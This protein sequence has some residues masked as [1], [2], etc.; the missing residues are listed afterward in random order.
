MADNKNKRD[1]NNNQSNTDVQVVQVSVRNLVE[2]ILRQGDIDNRTTGSMDK[3]A[4]LKG[5][6]I[7][8][9]IQS[10]MGS[11]YR[12]E[13][14]LK[15]RVSFNDMDILVEGRADGIFADG[16]EDTITI[17]EIKGVLRDLF[18]ITK[19]DEIDLAQGKCYAYMYALE[20]GLKE[21]KVQMTYCQMDTEE[22]ERFVEHFQVADLERWFLDLVS[23]YEK[24]A[25][26][27]YEWRLKRNESIRNTDFPFEYR[28]GQKE[29]ITSVYTTIMRKK[30][31]FIQAPTG[32]GKT[33]ATVFPSVKAVGEELGEK[34]FYLTAKTITRT[35]AE[36]AFKLLQD[37]GLIWKSITLTAKEKICFYEE[38][39]CNPEYCEYAKGHYDRINDTLYEM[40]INEDEV[41]RETIE[42]YAGK[43]QVCPYEMSLD[44]SLWADSV[45]CDYNYAFDPNVHLKR[46]FAAGNSGSYLFLVD[47]AH[48]LVER[49]REMYSATLYKEEILSVRRLVKKKAPKLAKRLEESNKQFLTLKKEC[50]SWQVQDSISHVYL[51]LLSIMTEMEGLFENNS[52]HDLANGKSKSQNI[53]PFQ[54]IDL[55][56]GEDGL[57]NEKVK[58]LEES[59]RK[60]ILDLYFQIRHFLNMYELLDDNYVVYTEHESDGR[61]KLKLYCVNPAKNLQEFLRRGNSTIFFSATLLPIHYY[62]KLLSVEADDYA[63]YA[64]STFLKQNRKLLIGTDVSTKYTKRTPKMYSEIAH[65]ILE[66]VK[67]RAG[68]YIAFFPSYKFMEEVFHV[69][70]ETAK[71]CTLSNSEIEWVIQSK[72]MNEEAREIFLENFEEDRDNSLVGFCVLGGIFS[73][74][75]DLANEKLIGAIIVGTGLPQIG[76]EREILK[77]HFDSMAMPGFDYAYLYPGMNKVLQ[78]AGRVIRTET[79][80][81]VILLLDERFLQRQYQEMFPREWSEIQTCKREDVLGYLEKFW[82]TEEM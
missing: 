77:Q 55:T 18:Y 47:E 81:G 16:S 9:K 67:G 31:L 36:H 49:G 69:F 82:N 19:P 35:V 57:G 39:N 40:L 34:V 53:E 59:D 27:A 1:K 46:F 63:V 5:S 71:A 2:F 80:K 72:Y 10:R 70:V 74:G 24:W 25:R 60:K 33:L 22:I 14:P 75:I 11:N 6:R 50:E 3:N 29:L 62:K 15:T 73:E 78:A 17:D 66:T 58:H 51:K 28:E 20:Q 41:K 42:E 37:K 61:F 65:F 8:R 43:F 54:R 45:I 32:V 21:I 4:M 23:K 38:A 52:R 26:F 12:A 79:D 13:V 64:E 56:K 68:N 48:N 7:H 76:N 30:K 44:Y